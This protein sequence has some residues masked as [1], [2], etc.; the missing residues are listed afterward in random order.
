MPR[1]SY[2]LSPLQAVFSV[3]LIFSIIFCFVNVFM[4]VYLWDHGKS[5][6]EIGIF[7]LFSVSSI[8]AASLI[9]AYLLHRLG[10]RSTFILSSL[11]ALLLFLYLFHAKDSLHSSLP[12]LG[13][14]YGG[15][16]G[17]FYIGFNLQILWISDAGNRSF[18][19][20]LESM[21]TT[22]AQL[23]T[24]FC[25]GLFIVYYGYRYTFLMILGLLILQLVL[26][27][28]VPSTRMKE[29]FRKRYF[30]LAENEDMAKMGFTCAAYGF[31]FAFVQMSYG[32]FLFFFLQDEFEL[33][34]WNFVFGGVSAFMYWIVGRSL[35]QSN[36]DILIGMGM[37]CS[38]IVTL[39]LLFSSAPWFVLF[40][41]V[42]SVS[43]PLLWIPAKS[44]HY[45]QMARGMKLGQM[46][47]RLVFR[48]FAISLGRICFF[49]LMIIGFDFKLGTSYYLMIVFACFMPVGIWI[50]SKG[51]LDGKEA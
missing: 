25:A 44:L 35:N 24:P 50:M 38:M 45:A 36:R 7:N 26:S 40:N 28:Q 29:S 43:L 9:G 46:M 20:G 10:T 1:K 19:I 51:S 12:L 2:I 5:F 39:T 49:L 8:F 4:N 31:Y 16:V 3:Q 30:F 18:L 33:G 41:L 37:I 15:Y 21:I 14:L 48:E 17:L 6:R 34:A 22:L 32:L 11:L 23:I 27:T 42:I 47:Q 13:A